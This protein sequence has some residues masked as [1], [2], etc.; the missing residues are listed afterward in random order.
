MAGVRRLLVDFACSRW[1]DD[2]ECTGCPKRRYL[3]PALQR[4]PGARGWLRPVDDLPAISAA[5]LL[6]AS[7]DSG[8]YERCGDRFGG[9]AFRGG[10]P[11]ESHPNGGNSSLGSGLVLAV[12]PLP[13][14]L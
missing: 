11:S 9:C 5:G 12:P 8:S 2:P 14:R 1:I 6:H 13:E 10:S 4:R 7:F 3:S